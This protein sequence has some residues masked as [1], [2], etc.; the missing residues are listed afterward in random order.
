MARIVG[1]NFKM[2]YIDKKMSEMQCLERKERLAGVLFLGL[3]AVEEGKA[4]ENNK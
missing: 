2:F 1:M 3:S 4:E